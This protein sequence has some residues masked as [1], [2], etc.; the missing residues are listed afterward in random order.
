VLK[1]LSAEASD[2]AML[3]TAHAA[4]E[5]TGDSFSA[6][7]QKAIAVEHFDCRAAK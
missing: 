3:K 6:P 7:L 1:D 5:A 2:A 4:L